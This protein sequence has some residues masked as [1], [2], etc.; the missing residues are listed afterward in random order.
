MLD[1]EVDTP[2]PKPISPKGMKIEEYEQLAKMPTK[3][4]YP[5]GPRTQHHTAPAMQM[6]LC[7]SKVTTVIN[8][9]SEFK[10]AEGFQCLL[11]CVLLVMI[12]ISQ[13]YFLQCSHGQLTQFI[14]DHSS[15]S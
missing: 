2:S 15:F 9:L 13:F 11:I 3:K 14:Q 6:M 5:E 1:P 12:A 7:T 4:K 8:V 10:R